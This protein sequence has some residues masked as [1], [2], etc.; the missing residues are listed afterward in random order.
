MK[1]ITFKPVDRK[2]FLLLLPAGGNQAWPE[3]W[4]QY[5]TKQG[6]HPACDPS[7][8]CCDR[9]LWGSGFHGGGGGQ[10]LLL[11]DNVHV[12]KTHRGFTKIALVRDLG[13]RPVPCQQ[14]CVCSP[15]RFLL[16]W[17]IGFKTLNVSPV[18]SPSCAETKIGSAASPMHRLIC[19][20]RM[21]KI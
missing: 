18:S 13:W 14:S 8:N 17:Y 19:H 11:S 20:P 21:G 6:D 5:E 12:C 15:N 3:F 2:Y 1:K 7:P 16:R 10:S 4:Q 9:C